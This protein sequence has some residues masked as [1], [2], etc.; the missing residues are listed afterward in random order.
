[1]GH[2]V[3]P[4]IPKKRKNTGVAYTRKAGMSLLN[5]GEKLNKHIGVQFDDDDDDAE[6]N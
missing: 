1:M 5:P 3:M 4:R 6:D 2:S